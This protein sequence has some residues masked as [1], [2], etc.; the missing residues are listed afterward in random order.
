MTTSPD[1]PDQQHPQR[2]SNARVLDLVRQ[3]QRVDYGDVLTEVIAAAT[4]DLTLAAEC[5]ARALSEIAVAAPTLANLTCWPTTLVTTV[6]APADR[7]HPRP[8][9]LGPLLPG[10]DRVVV[11]IEHPDASYQLTVLSVDDV[12]A[13]ATT[14]RTYDGGLDYVRLSPADLDAVRPESTISGRLNR[15]TDIA[16][17]VLLARLL[18]LAL[19]D[20]LARAFLDEVT[21]HLSHRSRQWRGA[22]VNTIGEDPHVLRDL[23]LIVARTHAVDQLA[24][25]AARHLQAWEQDGTGT[26]V[27]KDEIDVARIYARDFLTEATVEVFDLMGPTS[28]GLRDARHR[29]WAHAQNLAQRF[30]ADTDHGYTP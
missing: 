29:F 27:L 17:L 9:V 18:E 28:V 26:D 8:F 20:G 11:V 23:G 12:L 19:A 6:F 4:T 25:D 7:T 15:D 22:P 21:A 13:R 24:I 14:L 3:Q 5:R 2:P 10:F 30:D 16:R 1:P